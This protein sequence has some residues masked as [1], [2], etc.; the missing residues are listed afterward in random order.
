LAQVFVVLNLL[1]V[2]LVLVVVDV[3]LLLDAGVFWAH[4]QAD[5]KADEEG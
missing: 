5:Q 4:H 3:G 1:L 2:L